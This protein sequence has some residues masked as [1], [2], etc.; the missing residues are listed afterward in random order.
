LFSNKK[1]KNKNKKFEMTTTTNSGFYSSLDEGLRSIW[2]DQFTVGE[3]FF[4]DKKQ[5]SLRSSLFFGE[6]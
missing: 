6:V 4:R 1:K 3:Q 2:T 5:T